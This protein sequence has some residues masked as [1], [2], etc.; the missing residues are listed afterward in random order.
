[1]RLVARVLDR[2]G[3]GMMRWVGQLMYYDEERVGN[4]G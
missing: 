1:M 2:V 3:F 4:T